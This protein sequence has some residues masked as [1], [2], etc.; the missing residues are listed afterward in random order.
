MTNIQD[1]LKFENCKAIIQNI[2]LK[3]VKQEDKN[4]KSFQ[5]S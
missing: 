3:V 2:R 1:P 4:T 5:T